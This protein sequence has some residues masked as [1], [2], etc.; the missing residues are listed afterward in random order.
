M[1]PS[2]TVWRRMMASSS[3][4]FTPGL[5]SSVGYRSFGQAKMS[6]TRSP[7]ATAWLPTQLNG[8]KVIT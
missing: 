1:A 2:T 5:S 4:I 7:V 6:A 3:V 8:G